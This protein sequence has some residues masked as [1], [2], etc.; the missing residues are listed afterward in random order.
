MYMCTYHGT[1]VP[2]VLEYHG[3]WYTYDGYHTLAIAIVPRTTGKS[4]E[5]RPNGTRVPY[6]VWYSSTMV[7]EYG[8]QYHGEW[9]LPFV[10][11]L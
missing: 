5:T 2:L 6:M 3:T 7:L 10:F 8:L 11:L 1:M 4:V 9:L